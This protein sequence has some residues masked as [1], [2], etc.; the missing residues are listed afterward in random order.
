MAILNK[1]LYAAIG[2][3]TALLRDWVFP[4]CL[5]ASV[6]L[7]V[8]FR[9]AGNYIEQCA[10]ARM[11]SFHNIA[12]I[13]TCLSGHRFREEIKNVIQRVIISRMT[14][15]C[16]GVRAGQ[17]HWTLKAWV[18]YALLVFIS[19]LQVYDCR[20]GK[21]N[22]L[23]S[24]LIQFVFPETPETTHH[25]CHQMGL[26]KTIQAISVAYIFKHEWPLLIV[27]PSSLKYPWIEELE[28][29][30]PELDPRDINL[31]ESKTDTMYGNF[32]FSRCSVGKE[33][34]WQSHLFSPLRNS[35]LALTF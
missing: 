12:W 35:F 16:S 17:R 22:L 14:W 25:F 28:K 29:W 3:H 19:L 23:F 8:E 1:P 33:V 18:R 32:K 6:K 27:V 13:N 30:L 21:S 2:L 24:T 7:V 26:G 34:N 4:S 5:A 15:R 11:P 9:C 10:L 20:W 31:V